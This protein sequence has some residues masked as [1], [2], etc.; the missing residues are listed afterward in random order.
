[1][2][3]INYQISLSLSLALSFRLIL[4]WRK[5]T[6]N[7]ISRQSSIPQK[8][9]NILRYLATRR[10]SKTSQYAAQ[11]MKIVKKKRV[12]MEQLNNQLQTEWNWKFPFLEYFFSP[13]KI[14]I[15]F[16]WIQERELVDYI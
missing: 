5:L 13:S 11:W 1:M 4:A 10:E 3:V 2:D 14:P 12:N 8:L 16:T 15:A 7:D 9:Q 6:F